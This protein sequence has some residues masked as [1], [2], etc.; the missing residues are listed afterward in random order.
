MW[1]ALDYG[2]EA[3]FRYLIWMRRQYD[4]FFHTIPLLHNNALT[5]VYFL[6]SFFSKVFM[7]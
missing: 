2:A 3:Q 6:F 7:H 4:L 5:A 1:E